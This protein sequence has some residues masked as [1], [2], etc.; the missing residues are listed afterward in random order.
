[1][2][3]GWMLEKAKSSRSSASKLFLSLSAVKGT[4]IIVV[5][6]GAILAL[7][8]ARLETARNP[9]EYMLT[10]LECL[11]SLATVALLWRPR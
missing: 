8:E 5:T 1:M 10:A 3:A 11:R 4:V 7:S 2:H 9:L 6:R